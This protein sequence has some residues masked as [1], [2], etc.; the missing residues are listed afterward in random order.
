MDAPDKFVGWLAQHQHVDRKF[1]Y[2]YQYHPRSD[3]HSIALCTFVLEDLLA[4]SEVL[5]KQ[6]RA[7]KIGYGVNVEH[8][9]PNGKKKAIDL[10]IGKPAV[11]NIPGIQTEGMVR[12][13]RFSQVLISCEAKAVMTEHKK[14]QP[15]VFDELSSSHEIV[16]QGSPNAIAAGITVVNIGSSFASPLRQTAAG[17]LVVTKHRQPG[18]AESMIKHLAALPTRG[19][20]GQVGFDAYCTIVVESDNQK[21]AR[22]WTDAPAPQPGAPDHYGT[23]VKRIAKFYAERFAVLP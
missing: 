16:H 14:S 12:T 18:V 20:V 6:A 15:R 22:L 11:G 19:K 8:T 13:E 21:I 3:A 4:A 9:W 2:V 5:R 1:G 10:A 23:F 17:S 7:E